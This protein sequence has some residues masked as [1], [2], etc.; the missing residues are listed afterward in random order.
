VR[1][2][3]GLDASRRTWFAAERIEHGVLAVAALVIGALRQRT[4]AG[5]L[6]R[7]SYAE[8]SSPVVIWLT[9]G[10]VLLSAGAVALVA[11][12]V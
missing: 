8:L 7:G 5:A 4:T 10:A 1:P 9:A 11:V 6:R 3:L 12:R 2:V